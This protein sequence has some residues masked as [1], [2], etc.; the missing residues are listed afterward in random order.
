LAYTLQI[1]REPLE[2]RLAI[3][4][5]SIESLTE[6]LMQYAQGQTEIAH[7]FH[8]NVKTSKAHS[9]LLIEGEAG[10]AFLNM[11]IEK[12]EL[13]KLAQLWILGVDIDWQLLY[14]KPPKP[15]RIALPTYPFAR[16]RYWIPEKETSLNRDH[17]QITQRIQSL[18][19][20]PTLNHLE[21]KSTR[22]SIIKNHSLEAE[23][24]DLKQLFS[25]ALKLDIIHLDEHSMLEEFGVDSLVLMD[26]VQK[27]SRRYQLKLK[28][29]DLIGLNT[30]KD[31]AHYIIN[32]QSSATDIKKVKPESESSLTSLGNHHPL[33]RKND[34]SHWYEQLL[35]NDNDVFS[36]CD[37]L[38]IF[39]IKS[40]QGIHIEILSCGKGTPVVLLPPIDCLATAWLYQ[41]LELSQQFQVL[42]FHYPGYG[43]SEFHDEQSHFEAIGDSILDLL[44]LININ[45]P[46][47]LVGWSLGGF[48]SQVMA[49][50]YAPHIKSLTLVNTT[51]KLEEDDS[52]ENA[53]KLAKLLR[54]DFELHLPKEMRSKREGSLDF[55]KATDNNQIS[56]HY[57]HQV[58]QFDFRSQMASI[59]IPTLVIAGG[60][61]HITPPRY[62]EWIHNNIKG[63]KYEKLDKGGHYMP[64]QN[65]EYFNQQ[66]FNF[67]QTKSI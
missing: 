38:N 45:Q 27:M 11:L 55:I 32:F 33:F 4:V 10:E 46:F 20:A 30:I 1:G 44:N 2:E 51:A 40:S 47:H 60:E 67:I 61:D 36:T 58:L 48:I 50:K 6:K 5:D 35:E 62:A 13:T 18:P 15:Q 63:S 22:Q 25:E 3:V 65:A 53:F 17:E 37:N 52:I 19:D 42:V 29:S 59:Q 43:N 54:D 23:I 64:L 66:W 7:F 39:Q 49:K 12:Q 28:I 8:G 24:D 26:V 41:I 57:I 34:P 31:F 56:L 14:P 21:A 16:Q 9:A